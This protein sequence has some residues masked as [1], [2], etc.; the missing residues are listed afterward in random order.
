MGQQRTGCTGLSP[1]FIVGGSSWIRPHQRAVHRLYVRL[2]Y[3]H[4]GAV[5]RVD[6]VAGWWVTCWSE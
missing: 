6:F 2:D 3:V 4:R 1:I 5:E